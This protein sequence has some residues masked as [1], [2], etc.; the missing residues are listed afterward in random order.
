[1]LEASR[2]KI[3]QMCKSGGSICVITVVGEKT[4]QKMANTRNCRPLRLLLRCKSESDMKRE[5]KV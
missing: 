5:M 1:M 2:M 3:G 4:T